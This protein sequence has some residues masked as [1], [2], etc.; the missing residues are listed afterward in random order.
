[1]SSV[2]AWSQL[3]ILELSVGR[4]PPSGRPLPNARCSR[5]SHFHEKCFLTLEER[6]RSPTD[7]RF[8]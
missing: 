5:K 1:M 4:R 6:Y 8:T 2:V 3:W 7:Q